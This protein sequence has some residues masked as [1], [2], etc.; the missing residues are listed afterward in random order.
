MDLYRLFAL[1][2]GVQR[3]EGRKR[4]HIEGLLNCACPTIDLSFENYAKRDPK[5]FFSQT[6]LKDYFRP[7]VNDLLGCDCEECE[8]AKN[9]DMDLLEVSRM[10]TLVESHPWILGFMIYLGKLHYIYYWIKW[11]FFNS[12]GELKNAILEDGFVEQN[13]IE[14]EFDRSIF[15]KAYNR[16]VSMFFPMDFQIYNSEMCPYRDLPP[17]R[18]FPYSKE[19]PILTTGFYGV[20][21]KVEIVP[22]YLDGRIINLVEKQY[23]TSGTDAG[24]DR[25]LLFALKSV[26]MK[27]PESPLRSME[28]NVLDMVSRIEKPASDNM[29]TLLFAYKWKDQIHFL[30]PFIDMNLDQVLRHIKCP[31][32][33]S[34]RLGREEQLIEH[35]LWREM[36]GVCYALSVFHKMMKDPFDDNKGIVIGLHFDLK[37]ANILV[38]TD[39]K[40]KITDFGQSIIQILG[41]GDDMT[42]PHNPGDSRYAAP[43][44]RPTLDYDKDDPED[45]QVL[46]NYDVWS[47]GCIMVEVLINILGPPTLEAFDQELAEEKNAGF[48]TGTDLKKCVT[49]SLQDLQAKFHDTPQGHYMVTVAELILKML[50]HDVK[51]RPYSWQVFDALQ[52]AE[53]GL[54]N[55]SEQRDSITPKVNA[56]TIPDGAGFKELGWDNGQSIVSFADKTGI[57]IELV[58]QS[59]GH[60][61]EQPRPC[62]IRL[63]RG[64][65][66]QKQAPV[67]IALVWGVDRGGMVDVEHRRVELSRWCFSPTYL[68]QDDP[69]S[70]GRFE[71]RLFPIMGPPGGRLPYDRAFIFQFESLEVN[72]GRQVFKDGGKSAGK[73]SVNIVNNIAANHESYLVK[74]RPPQPAWQSQNLSE[75]PH[76]SSSIFL[77]AD[78]QAVWGVDNEDLFKVESMKILLD[79]ENDFK[80]LRLGISSEWEQD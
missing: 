67:E 78:C 19:E 38:T 20:M 26:R 11:D 36:K 65:S 28:R 37:P 6:R 61:E 17:S 8:N 45:I 57:T 53:S 35:W 63:F 73:H 13:L 44:S 55:P 69:N 9:A 60:R 25:R 3:C 29:I 52:K 70:N 71:C 77:E 41:K 74:Q 59:D 1:S 15:Q 18:R 76:A 50:S 54:N 23:P 46:L 4:V 49:S 80:R 48:C 51:K 21:T 16:A 42:V 43:E 22:E 58:N 75:K 47:L 56:Y 2:E 64:S 34:P 5:M 68:F 10:T 32:N 66:K 31:R 40:L 62:R 72:N 33:L 7:N 79:S 14:A 30:F 39:G 24:S 12:R 27:G